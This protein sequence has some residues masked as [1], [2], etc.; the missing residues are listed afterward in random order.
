M[1]SKLTKKDFNSIFIRSLSCPFS[2]G[3]E[4]QENMAYAYAMIP[5]LK[6]IYADNKKGMSEA[7]KRHL[8]FFNITN[9]CNT[10]CLGMS[11]AMEEEAAA[12]EDFDANIINNTK[13]A[14]MGPLSGIGD[15]LF[16][17]TF[18]ILATSI[19]TVYSLKGSVLGPIL[20]WLAYNIPAFACRIGLFH[21]GYGSGTKFL[22]D[23]KTKSAMNKLMKGATILGLFIIGAMTASIV[24]VNI[25]VKISD[26]KNV[27][28][29][30]ELINGIIPQLTS[31]LIFAGTY[32]AIVNKKISANRMIIIFTVVALFGAYFG[33]LA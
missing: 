2:F 10:F 24:S 31:L 1:T 27:Q 16:W 17:G 11:I 9:Q 32:F 19:G 21:A 6:K 30:S 22:T 18:K 15:S 33:V 3:Y 23:A 14:L 5:A 25:P 29:I 7:L 8:A 28:T 26:G 20:Y 12:N 4:K 13:V